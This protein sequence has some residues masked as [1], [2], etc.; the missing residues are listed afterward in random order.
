MSGLAELRWGFLKSGLRGM[1]LVTALEPVVLKVLSLE[2]GNA[3]CSPPASS[4]LS[5][6]CCPLLC[7][8]IGVSLLRGALG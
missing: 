3:N 7:S 8:P 4:C 6:W 1:V 2:I 5:H